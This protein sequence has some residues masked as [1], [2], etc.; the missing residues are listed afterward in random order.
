MYHGIVRIL[1]SSQGVTC[2]VVALCGNMMV[3][4][5]IRF[6]I[7]IHLSSSGAIH[8]CSSR[9]MAMNGNPQEAGHDRRP[10]FIILTFGSGMMADIINSSSDCHNN[11]NSRQHEKFSKL[12]RDRK[13]L[14][15]KLFRQMSISRKTI[16]PVR[17]LQQQG[18]RPRGQSVH[19]HLSQGYRKKSSD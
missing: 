17:L 16:V 14:K 13:T 3:R 19:N 4:L 6:M 8:N 18:Q 15:F 2:N 11:H 12:L 9:F 10:T 1:E 7:R 5:E